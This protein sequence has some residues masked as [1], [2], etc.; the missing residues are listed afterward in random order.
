MQSCLDEHHGS[1]HGPQS[2]WV[3]HQAGQN[4]DQ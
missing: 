4:F 1:P 2:V 3:I